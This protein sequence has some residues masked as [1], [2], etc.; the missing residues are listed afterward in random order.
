MLILQYWQSEKERN[1]GHWEREILNFRLQIM[2]ELE[3]S[4]SLNNHLNNKFL[5]C[6]Q[7]GRKLASKH[8]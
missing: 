1:R 3:D 2:E 7:K 6:Y 4:P 5:D 8:S